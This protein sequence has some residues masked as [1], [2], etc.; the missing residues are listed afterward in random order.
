ML[1][2]ETKAIKPKTKPY[3]YQQDVLD[4]TRDELFWALFAEQ[5]LG[6]TKMTIDTADYL[7]HTDKIDR[8]MIVAP[9]GVHT[10]WISREIPKHS[11][12][13]RWTHAW[14]G[15]TTKKEERQFATIVDGYFEADG[16][17]WFAM[18]IESLRTKRGQ[19]YAEKFI[20][21]RTLFIVDES[22]VIKNPK[23]QQTKVAIALGAKAGY[24]RILSGTPI[25]QN[26]MDIWSQA[27]FLSDN[28]LPYR[29][30]VAFKAKYAI[31]VQQKMQNRVFNQIVGFQNLE[32]LKRE[33]EGWSTRLLKKDCLD[34]P[35]KIYSI[36]DVPFHKEQ[37]A[38]YESMLHLQIASLEHSERQGE[39]ITARN[40]MTA[41]NKL[42]QILCGFILNEEGEAQTV[43]TNRFNTLLEIIADTDEQMIIWTHHRYSVIQILDVLNKHY[44]NSA[45]GY[46][47]GIKAEERHDTVDRFQ[48]KKVRFI[49][50][51]AAA[52]KGLTLT[53]GTTNVYFTNSFNLET[54]LQSEDRSHRIGTVRGVNYIDLVTPNTV[55]EKILN[56][57]RQKADLSEAI[58][59]TGW[60]EILK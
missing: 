19:A 33:V 36:R 22:T 35:D 23:A 31:E 14:R 7:Y 27:K 51:N 6:K 1:L 59:E 5:G 2:T 38:L 37:Q 39:M 30:F 25:V 44:P 24:R 50:A 55:D 9:N 12:F 58:I 40:V 20:N 15:M 53:N 45:V 42:Q 13:G 16:I 10:N 52:S 56:R 41:L 34:L 54:R 32:S 49:V 11:H 26:P 29:S 28:A 3:S 4:R 46:Y 18:N 8:V 17:S 21:E 43:P 57:L 47:G 48:N 60:R